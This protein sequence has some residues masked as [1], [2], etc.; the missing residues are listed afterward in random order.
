ML[1]QTKI[2]RLV[3]RHNK[4]VKRHEK[5]SQYRHR[6]EVITSGKKGPHQCLSDTSV[7]IDGHWICNAHRERIDPK[8]L[9]FTFEEAVELSRR[10]RTDRLWMT[11]TDDDASAG[12]GNG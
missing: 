6:C 3:R 10:H 9:V 12:E 1:D 5:Q 11:T 8:L 7:F 4:T 2:D